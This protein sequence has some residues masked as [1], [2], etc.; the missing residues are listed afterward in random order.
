MTTRT[1][2]ISPIIEIPLIVKHVRVVGFLLLLLIPLAIFGQI[3]VPS[4][5][6]VPADAA[7]T[8]R[9]IM[10]S[11]SLFRV[12]TAPLAALTSSGELLVPLWLLIMGVNVEQWK[13]RA[14]ASA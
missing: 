7:A 3:Y 11:E 14:L 5:L 2:E 10:A 8:A 1:A 6:I 9:N 12:Y 13:K 4:A